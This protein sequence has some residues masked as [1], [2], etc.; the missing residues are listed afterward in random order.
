MVLLQH[1]SVFVGTIPVL[2]IILKI[3]L[4]LNNLGGYWWIDTPVYTIADSTNT[5][6]DPDNGLVYVDLLTAASGRTTPIFI[7]I[8]LQQDN[9]Q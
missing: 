6:V 8:L 5:F 9:K 4:I 7:I 1:G 2:E 3:M